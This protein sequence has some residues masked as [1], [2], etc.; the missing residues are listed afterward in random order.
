MDLWSN[1]WTTGPNQRQLLRRRL[2]GGDELPFV[3]AVNEINVEPEC[4]LKGFPIYLVLHEWKSLHFFREHSIQKSLR[5]VGGHSRI[6]YLAEQ[7]KNL[8]LGF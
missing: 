3:H 4:A 6:I 7:S 8:A 2:E 5:L 1:K